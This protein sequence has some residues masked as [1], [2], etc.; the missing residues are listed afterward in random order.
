MVRQPL[1]VVKKL[2][3]RSL[4]TEVPIDYDIYVGVSLIHSCCMSPFF[5]TNY[6]PALTSKVLQKFGGFDI[7]N[8]MIDITVPNLRI[9]I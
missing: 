7:G 2:N 3:I 6:S 8:I 9:L 1:V 5:V 4:F